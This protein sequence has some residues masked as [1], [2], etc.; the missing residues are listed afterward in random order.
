MTRIPTMEY[1][2]FALFRI[3]EIGKNCIAAWEEKYGKERLENTA[4]IDDHV[5]GP[6]SHTLRNGFERK[7][8]TQKG[9]LK[10][11][12]QCSFSKT[13]TLVRNQLV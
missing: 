8:K 13:F 11:S 1:T 2:F 9:K 4:C 3:D 10:N 7:L 5:G 6:P 12:I